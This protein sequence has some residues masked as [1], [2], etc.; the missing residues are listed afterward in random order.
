MNRVT[1]ALVMAGIIS[2]SLTA[3][4]LLNHFTQPEINY[5]KCTYKGKTVLIVGSYIAWKQDNFS[6]KLDQVMSSCKFH[7]KGELET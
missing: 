1:K 6:I 2:S 4:F 7:D 5:T 3:G